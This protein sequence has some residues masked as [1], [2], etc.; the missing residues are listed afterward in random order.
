MSQAKRDLQEIPGVGPRIAGYLESVG[1]HHVADLRG[2]APEDLYR[3]LCRNHA[4]SLDR[5]LLYVLRCA[6][7]YASPRRPQSHLLKWWHWKDAAPAE[8]KSRPEGEK[9]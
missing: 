5:C 2:A 8:S 9:K 6:V 4:R 1:V 3:R 7:Y